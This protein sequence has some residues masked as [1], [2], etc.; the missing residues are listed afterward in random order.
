MCSIDMCV[1]DIDCISKMDLEFLSYLL[2]RI[3][4]SLQIRNPGH[5]HASYVTFNLLDIV[6]TNRFLE[7]RLAFICSYMGIFLVFKHEAKH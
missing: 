5:S 3:D 1:L 7:F 4:R 2:L 6:K